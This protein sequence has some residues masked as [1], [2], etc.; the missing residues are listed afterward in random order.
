MSNEAPVC[1]ECGGV[2]KSGGLVLCTRED[3]GRRTCRAVWRC[4]G[5]HVWWRW[6]D[7]ADSPWERCPVP[8]AFR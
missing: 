4:G 6:A 2:M 5:R 1:P 7:R 8:G 3:D